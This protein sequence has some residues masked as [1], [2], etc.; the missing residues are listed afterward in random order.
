MRGCRWRLGGITKGCRFW[1]EKRYD[2][3]SI[4]VEGDRIGNYFRGEDLVR[5]LGRTIEV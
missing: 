2:E 5:I 3:P 1:E 4:L